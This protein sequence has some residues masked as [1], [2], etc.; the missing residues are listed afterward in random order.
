MNPILAA[1]AVLGTFLLVVG[2]II[3][4]FAGALAAILLATNPLHAYFGLSRR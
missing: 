4:A 1:L 2:A 3:G